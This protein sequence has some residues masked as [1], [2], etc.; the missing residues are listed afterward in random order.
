MP[1]SPAPPE[2]G[3]FSTGW[4]QRE[5]VSAGRQ[6]LPQLEGPPKLLGKWLLDDRDAGPRRQSLTP[7]HGTPQP[8]PPLSQ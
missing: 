5:R 6:D 3:L 7:A 1:V 2:P 4:R 8:G